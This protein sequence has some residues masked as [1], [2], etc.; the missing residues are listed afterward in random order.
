MYR[1]PSVKSTAGRTIRLRTESLEAFESISVQIGQRGW[2][3]AVASI[4][5]IGAFGFL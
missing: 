1:W 5:T 2:L 4:T 3:G